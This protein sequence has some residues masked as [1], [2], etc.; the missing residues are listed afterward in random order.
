MSGWKIGDLTKKLSAERTA[1]PVATSGVE[2]VVRLE[3]IGQ[4]AGEAGS[5]TTI[6]T[7]VETTLKVLASRDADGTLVLRFPDGHIQRALVSRD[8][9]RRW[10][11]AHAHTFVASEVIKKRGA[12]D[13]HASLEAPM[14]GKVTRILVAVGDRVAKGQTLLAVEAMKMEH[15]IKS[16]KDGIIESIRATLGELVSPGNPLCTVGDLKAETPA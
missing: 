15:A 7:T 5:E 14:P 9:K 16:P 2:L 13:L 1:G 4:A 10:V 12:A 8:G 3:H 6:E 11:T